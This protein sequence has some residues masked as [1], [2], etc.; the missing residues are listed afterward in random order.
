M[1]DIHVL[2]REVFDQC[3]AGDLSEEGQAEFMMCIEQARL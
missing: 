1:G 3:L 2:V